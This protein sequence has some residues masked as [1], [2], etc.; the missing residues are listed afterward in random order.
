M[1]WGPN[2]IWGWAPHMDWGR[3][4]GDHFLVLICMTK[5]EAPIAHSHFEHSTPAQN[6]FK[7]ASQKIKTTQG[8][9]TKLIWYLVV[10]VI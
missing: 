8:W 2:N 4:F 10:D 3:Y 1:R 5:E 7:K 6:Q 9:Y